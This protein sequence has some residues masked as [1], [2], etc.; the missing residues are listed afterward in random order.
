M[1]FPHGVSP[2]S[3]ESAAVPSVDGKPAVRAVAQIDDRCRC[4]VAGVRS[5]G[6]RDRRIVA[7]RVAANVAVGVLRPAGA[8]PAGACD[9]RFQ[10][11]GVVQESARHTVREHGYTDL[12][13]TLPVAGHR[14]RRGGDSSVI[15]ANS[16]TGAAFMAIQTGKPRQ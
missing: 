9:R 16:S 6:R 12:F 2:S 3:G 15:D 11:R 10:I 1:A 8:G 4:C 7:D 13:T 5:P 14:R